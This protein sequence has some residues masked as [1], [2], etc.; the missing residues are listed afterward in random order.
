[1][2]LERRLGVEELRVARSATSPSKRTVSRTGQTR[3]AP[4]PTDARVAGKRIDSSERHQ[5]NA[6]RPIVSTPP[7]KSIRRS[8]VACAN[9]H[10]ST[11]R[12]VAG[13]VNDS[14]AA[15]HGYFTSVPKAAS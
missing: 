4:S 12:T 5:S 8:A 2:R 3:S 6:P 7:G 15:A 13:T 11:A 14:A 9:A 10:G 1:M